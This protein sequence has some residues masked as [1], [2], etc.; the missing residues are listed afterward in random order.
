MVDK[1]GEGMPGLE[2]CQAWARHACIGHQDIDVPDIL[3]N[4]LGDLLQLI[5][6]GDVGTERNHAVLE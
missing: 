2:I 5:F 6:L 1:L 4:R 3:A